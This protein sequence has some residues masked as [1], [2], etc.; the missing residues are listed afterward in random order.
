VSCPFLLTII[1]LKESNNNISP[2][3]FSSG[4]PSFCGRSSFFYI[5]VV[6]NRFYRLLWLLQR[7]SPLSFLYNSEAAAAQKRVSSVHSSE[8]NVSPHF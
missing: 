3:R 5:F 6:G 2:Q 4:N 7:V 1:F 8:T